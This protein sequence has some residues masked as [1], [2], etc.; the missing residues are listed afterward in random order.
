MRV[1]IIENFVAYIASN[2]VL[3]RKAQ[4][5]KKSTAKTKVKARKSKKVKAGAKSKVTAGKGK[6]KNVVNGKGDGKKPS[7]SEDNKSC[8]IFIV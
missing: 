5:Q 3:E 7:P 2:K 6:Q 4:N 1:L 8:E